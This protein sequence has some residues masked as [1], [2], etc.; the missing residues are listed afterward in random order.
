MKRDLMMHLEIL[1]RRLHLAGVDGDGFGHETLEVAAQ[2]DTFH[3][4]QSL[5]G[6]HRPEHTI[7]DIKKGHKQNKAVKTNHTMLNTLR[8]FVFIS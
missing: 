6:E 5:L 7:T 1:K 2:T 3:T 4:D 8:V